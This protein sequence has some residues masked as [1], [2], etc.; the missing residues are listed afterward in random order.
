MLVRIGHGDRA[1][2]T[3]PCMI[4]ANIHFPREQSIILVVDGA[5]DKL[6]LPDFYFI[7]LYKLYN[8]AK[9]IVSLRFSVM[10]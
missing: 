1:R 5:K 2:R 10:Y 3:A 8:G 4:S 6:I 7:F 9:I